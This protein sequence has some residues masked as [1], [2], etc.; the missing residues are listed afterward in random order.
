MSVC[1]CTADNPCPDA[2]DMLTRLERL[3]RAAITAGSTEVQFYHVRHW[4][5]LWSAYRDHMGDRL[6][7]EYRWHWDHASTALC[8]A[9]PY[10]DGGYR[11]LPPP[12]PETK[13]PPRIC[14]QCGG[15]YTKAPTE[16]VRFLKRRFCSRACALAS[17][18]CSPT[19]PLRRTV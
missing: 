6:P 8:V 16:G 11:V 14:I 13:Y 4:R 19:S 15:E 2:A 1:D 17:G 7:V 3:E 9:V 5:W 12:R 10:P 18:V